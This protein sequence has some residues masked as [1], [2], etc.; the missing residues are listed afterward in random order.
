M[1]EIGIRTIIIK[2]KITIIRIIITI[3][4]DTEMITVATKAIIEI[5]GVITPLGDKK[6][7][8]NIEIRDLGGIPT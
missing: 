8:I 7:K 3:T 1:V 4:I 5:G 2:I 6:I